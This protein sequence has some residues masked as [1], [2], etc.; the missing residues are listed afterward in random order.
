[1]NWLRDKYTAIKNWARTSRGRRVIYIAIAVAIVAW[2]VFRFAS[3]AAQ[4]RMQIFN[5]A[6]MHISDGVPV[7]VLEMSRT[8]GVIMEPLSVKNN[9]AH[10]SGAR[11]KLFAAGQRVSTGQIVSV[12]SDIDLDSGMHV[13]Q[14]RGVENGMHMAEFRAHGYFVPVYAVYDNYVFV[15][16]DGVATT[17]PVTIARRDAEYAYI[18]SGLKDGDVVIL[19]RIN[20]GDKIQIKK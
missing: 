6:R 14:T 16:R 8:D 7:T 2:V 10:V 13:V 17:Q 3:I 4:N 5:P 20:D 1:M 12:S 15:V 19:S 11:K 9:R 18:T